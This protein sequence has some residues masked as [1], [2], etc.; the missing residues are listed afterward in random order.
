MDTLASCGD[1]ELARRIAA[2]DT[3]ALEAVMRRNNQR[4]YRAARSILDNEEEAEEAVQDAYVKA[5]RT[6]AGYQGGASLS[7]WLTR[8]VINEALSRRRK[9]LRRAE[10]IRLHQQSTPV[11]EREKLEM[12]HHSSN[13]PEADAQRAELRRLIERMIDELPEAFRTVFVLR[14]LEEMTVEETARCLG[15]AEATVRSRFFRARALLREAI[16]R[17]IDIGYEEAFAFAGAR[18][19]RIVARVLTRIAEMRLRPSRP[20][21]ALPFS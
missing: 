3:T 13:S 19:D 8:I 5:Y 9:Y 2:G 7:T 6:I 4:L 12:P 17:E 14:A 18:C 1:V 16:A 10:V 11:P 21:P 20:G 15:I